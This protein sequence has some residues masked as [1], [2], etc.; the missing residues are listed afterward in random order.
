MKKKCK[1]VFAFVFA[2]FMMC[3]VGCSTESSDPVVLYPDNGLSF[4]M[5]PNDM[6]KN[7]SAAA[8]LSHGLLLVVH[9]NA[10]Y[11]ISFDADPAISEPPEMQLFRLKVSFVESS[12]FRATQVRNLKAEKDGNRYVYR[13]VC[14]ESEKMYWAATLM[15]NDTYYKG[16]TKNIRFMGDGAYSDHMSLNLIVVGDVPSQLDGFTVDELAAEMLAN[17]R[18]FYT[19]VTIDTLYVNY[20]HEHP[21]IGQR[22]PADVSWIAGRTN[23][24]MMMT[25]LGGWPKIRNALDIV[26]VDFIDE[27]GIMGYSNLF[28]GNMDGGEGSTVI[29]GAKVK[30]YSDEIRLSKKDIIETALHETGHFFGLRH[31][32]ASS[33]DLGAL[34]DYSNVEDGFEDTPYCEGLLTSGLFKKHAEFSTDM[35]PYRRVKFFG[36]GIAE[37]FDVY[38][39]PDISNYMF[40]LGTEEGF[41]HFSDQQLT[42]LRASLMIFPH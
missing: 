30:G 11:E 18:K 17:Y 22:Y 13:F 38:K 19:S 29:L 2:I 23:S 40:P 28:S 20:A 26:L 39:C 36:A 33:A 15:Q 4:M 14:E 8:A 34:G 7:D 5:F 31:T 12:G 3:F 27:L 9:P 32:T 21:E 1:N 35:L 42:T 41:A 16:S 24:D 25:K 6:A 37:K 10:S